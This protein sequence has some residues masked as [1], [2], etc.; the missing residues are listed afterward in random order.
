MSIVCIVTTYN[1]HGTSQ[2]LSPNVA[3]T[4]KDDNLLLY[5]YELFYWVFSKQ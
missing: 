1:I 2:R 5:T 3:Q 4:H